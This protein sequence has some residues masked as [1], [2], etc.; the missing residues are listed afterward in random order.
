MGQSWS[1]SKFVFLLLL[2]WTKFGPF[3]EVTGEAESRRE[4]IYVF[5]AILRLI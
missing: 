2:K 3:E 5:P 1:F 4:S